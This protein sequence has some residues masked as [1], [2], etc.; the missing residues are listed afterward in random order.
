MPRTASFCTKYFVSLGFIAYLFCSV[1]LYRL[2]IWLEA[3]TFSN[4]GRSLRIVATLPI[5]CL[6]GSTVLGGV[7]PSRQM[8]H[9]T[10]I[11]VGFAHGYSKYSLPG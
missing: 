2:P 1:R 11:S 6:E 9:Y 5:S 8:L 3:N 4:R 7:L 10:L